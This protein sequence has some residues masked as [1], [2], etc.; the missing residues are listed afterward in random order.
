MLA[1]GIV[2]TTDNA[3]FYKLN[4]QPIMK[5][6]LC[7]VL[8]Y[9]VFMTFNA[10]SQHNQSL[11]SLQEVYLKQSDSEEKIL[12]V[13][14][15][16]NAV[17]YSDPDLAK[18]YALEELSLS[19]RFNK[20]RGIGMA[21]YHLGTYYNVKSSLDSAT[22]FFNKALNSFKKDNL[23]PDMALAYSAL[24]M[25]EYEKGNFDNA[26]VLID[27]VITIFQGL[28]DAYRTAVML[29]FKGGIYR[30]KGNYILA[31]DVSIQ[32]LRVID[33]LNK[34]IRKADILIQLGNIEFLLGHYKSSLDYSLQAYDIFKKYDDEIT[35]A[36]TAIDIGKTF[37]E[38]SNYSSA[39]KY[40]NQALEMAKKFDVPST[41]AAA[42]VSLGKV[43][44]ARGNYSKAGQ[45]LQEG[46]SLHEQIN[47][48]L[49]IAETL[50][51]LGIVYG[52]LKQF[53]ESKKYLDKAIQLYDALGAN[54]GLSDAYRNRAASFE[55]GGNYYAALMDY[56]TFHELK[57]T[58]FNTTKSKQIEEIRT[59]YET[60]KK[61]QE[62]HNQKNEIELLMQSARVISLQ[63]TFLATGL[64]LSILIIGIGYYA[65]KQ[66]MN[67]N[68]LVRE[69]LDAELEYKKKE[70]TSHALHLAKKNEVLEDLK[71]KAELL[72]K[73]DNDQKGYRQ[74]I[75]TIK[76][77]L[78]DD[79]N[80]ENFKIYFE[81]VHKN[82][83]SMVKN[84]FPEIT[85]NELR[86]MALLK[87]NLSSKEIAN[88]LNIT[89]EG[90][91]KAR[92]RLRKKMNIS[93]DDSLQD[94][95]I[96]L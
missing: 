79:N 11:D 95:I 38:L 50:N 62:I 40:L 61:E 55:M 14:H 93:S 46:L 18:R 74:L 6:R 72:N 13:S 68:K 57:D 10:I 23:K 67:R 19:E 71:Q 21:N 27:S 66:K 51:E 31:L 48:K 24:A 17:I 86:L 84:K 94:Q 22:F 77:N 44:I 28:Q 2:Q 52:H 45:L 81:Q 60:E 20:T 39:I 87:M 33:T 89:P 56:K 1:S 78:Q 8:I 70:L 26:M 12:T 53:E 90:I 88:I 76:Y 59:I 47:F 43:H 63:R 64:F 41:E 32:A 58:I 65:I 36:N 9:A 3:Y 49:E 96:H 29:G 75:N 30:D 92:Y 35:L 54:D 85:A 25:G 16:F 83:N 80:W 82:F 91:K 15:L 4:L 7:F 34:P 5:Y 69:K 42:L 37:L 73:S